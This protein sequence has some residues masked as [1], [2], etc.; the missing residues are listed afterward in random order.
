[1]WGLLAF[2]GGAALFGLV[3]RDPYKL[4]LAVFICIHGLVAVGLGRLMGGAGQ[5]SLGHAGFYG[6]GAYASAILTT[7]LGMNPWLALVVGAGLTGGVA[8][9]V[10]IPTLRLRGHYLA[11]GTLGLGMIIQIFFNQAEK[12]TEG[13]SGITAIPYLYLA[14]TPLNNDLRYY[15]LVW[16]VLWLGLILAGNITDSR[17]GR[18]LRALGENEGAAAAAGVNVARAKLAIFVLSA[19]YASVAGSLYAHYLTYISPSPFGFGFSIQLLVMVIL[20]GEAT[21]WG[22][23]VGCG[24]LTVL[25]QVLADAAHRFPLF[26][27]LETVAYGLILVLVLI[28]RP[29]GLMAPGRSRKREKAKP[30]REGSGAAA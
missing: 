12:L 3:V 8:C 22:P 25:H 20:G 7:R 11:M 26:D 13:P 1:M 24:V 14:G 15:Y 19:V 5:I 6:L 28:F 18:A 10:G 4:N 27:G 9:L 30:A 17:Y 2:A 21:I 16:P 29:Q 23:L